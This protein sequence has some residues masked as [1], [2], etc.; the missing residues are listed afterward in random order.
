MSF[1][2]LQSISTGIDFDLS[3]FYISP[4]PTLPKPGKDNLRLQKLLKKAAK[5]NTVL[6]SEQAKSFRSSLSPVNEASPDLQHHGSAAPAETPKTATAPSISL[7]SRF[8]IKP[9]THHVPSP[10]RKS[11]PFTLTV[12]EQRRIAE[13]LRFTTSPATSPLHKPGAPETPQQPEGTDTQLPSPRASSI[14]IFPQLPSSTTSTERAP[15]VTYITKVHTYFHSVK[16]PKA[17][18]PTSDQTQ[19]TRSNENKRPL[20]PAAEVSHSKSSP[21]QIPAPLSDSETMA[22]PPTLEPHPLSPAKAGPPSEALSPVPHK[23][24]IKAPYPKP[25]TSDA[26]SNKPAILGS[27]TETSG[28]ER[29]PESPKQHSETPRPST[30]STPWGQVP[31]E[32]ATPAQADTAGA[33]PTETKGEHAI[34]PQLAPSVPNTS[35]P[36]KAEPPLPL[37]EE[38]KPLGVNASGWYRLRK[39]LIVPPEAPSFPEP[40]PAKQ[41]Q[42]EASHGK[43]SSQT[44]TTQDSQLLKELA[45][46]PMTKIT[47]VFEVGQ[48]GP[49]VTEEHTKSFNRMATAWSVN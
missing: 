7:P 23:E 34:P 14:F 10:F 29:V 28:S 24:S 27:D 37:V 47:N 11:K 25:S 48:Y 31:T 46:K 44:S 33:T 43:D 2:Q 20:S 4:P 13:H 21:G 3:D 41:G 45:A 19:A 6:A 5:K 12:T 17:K 32:A 22:S 38:A 49:K 42:E 40:E 16:A 1:C 15:E 26:H 30:P 39:H 36:L 9:V 8:P 18:I 35:S